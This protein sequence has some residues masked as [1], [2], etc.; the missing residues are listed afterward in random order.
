MKFLFIITIVLLS[1]NVFSQATV[2]S[3]SEKKVS[4]SDI[5]ILNIDQKYEG[6][7][8]FV[9]NPFSTRKEGGLCITDVIINNTTIHMSKDAINATAFEIPLDKYNIKIG[10]NFNIKI[11]HQNG[12]MP[13]ILK[14]KK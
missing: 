9:N 1:N 8:I 4:D 12:C 11:Y 14:S 13:T 2:K 10:D 6:K 7:N 3:N 5:A